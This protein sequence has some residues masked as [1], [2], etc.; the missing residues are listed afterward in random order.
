V[1]GKGLRVEMAKTAS[2]GADRVLWMER[3]AR[4][5]P[6]SMKS[7]FLLATL[8]LLLVIGGSLVYVWSRIRVI[9]TGYE[10]SSAMKTGRVLTE[11]NK[12]F[13][14]EIATLKSYSRIEKIATE[15]LGMS[16]PRSDQVVIIR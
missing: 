12:R 11:E 6:A 9:Q 1:C 10:I 3:G 15:E 13:R 16:K 4:T 5:R 14:V 8:L 2:L 7:N